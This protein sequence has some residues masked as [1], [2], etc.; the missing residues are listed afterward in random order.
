MTKEEKKPESPH[1]YEAIAGVIKALSK[2]G[3]AKT[4]DNKQGAGYKF[5]GIDDVLNV[6]S[7]LLPEHG[8]VILP[9]VRTHTMT[10]RESKSG[11]ALYFVTLCVDYDFISVKDGTTHTVTAYGEAMDSSDK[12]TNKAMSAAY[13]SMVFITFCV[14]TEG[15]NDTENNTHEAKAQKQSAP[16]PSD[17][18]AFRDGEE[19]KQWVVSAINH[20]K[21]LKTELEISR[22]KDA[23]KAFIDSLGTKQTEGLNAAIEAQKKVIGAVMD[24]EVPF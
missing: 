18:G 20:V 8:L 15:D 6:L 12:A 17:F 19:R 1:V 16:N 14:P 24:D 11:G 5:R 7:P 4:R 10:E 2:E 13:K 9:R 22:Y 23:N 21:T 3:I